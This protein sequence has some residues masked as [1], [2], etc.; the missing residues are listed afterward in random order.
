M[1]NIVGE[2]LKRIRKERGLTQ[3]AFS[4]L[5]GLSSQQALARIENADTIP[6]HSTIEKIADGLN[7][8]ATEL[9][10]KESK[11][12]TFNYQ[13]YVKLK[14]DYKDL[15]IKYAHLKAE[16]TNYKIRCRILEA[17]LKEARNGK[18]G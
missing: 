11:P 15:L 10:R 14:A 17:D 12:I 18:D 7:I 4:K 13:D 5:I 9:F 3:E 8:D 16:L 2:N 1:T 6:K